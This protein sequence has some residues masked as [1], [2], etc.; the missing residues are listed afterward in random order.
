VALVE[1]FRVPRPRGASLTQP[2][3]HADGTRQ[4]PGIA[5]L[6]ACDVTQARPRPRWSASLAPGQPGP[7]IALCWFVR[8]LCGS[9][10]PADQQITERAATTILAVTPKAAHPAAAT[11]AMPAADAA[12][13]APAP[14]ARSCARRSRDRFGSEAL[15]ILSILAS[16]GP[17]P[18]PALR[19]S[20]IARFGFGAQ[21]LGRDYLA[22]FFMLVET[23]RVGDTINAGV[24]T[25]HV[26][27]DVIGS[28]PRCDVNGLC[29]RERLTTAWARVAGLVPRVIDSTRSPTGRT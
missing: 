2:A 7:V 18:C 6:L 21:E 20:G 16:P 28:P 14:S 23:I 5:C 26:R 17:A 8:C 13:T 25:G 1:E 27:G 9:L 29:A 10:P 15:T 19:C 22:A 4:Q 3:G 11:R 24:A 12:S